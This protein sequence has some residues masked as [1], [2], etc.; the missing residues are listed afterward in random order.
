MNTLEQAQLTHELQDTSFYDQIAKDCTK[1]LIILLSERG[2]GKS[3]SL[4]TIVDHC[5]RIHPNLSFKIFDVSQAWYHNAPVQHRQFVNGV[6][7]VA[8]LDDCVYEIGALNEAQRRE[9]V[10][11]VVKQDWDYRYNLKLLNPYA[12][13]S[14]PWVIYVFEEANVYFGSYSFRKND[15]FSQVLQDF[16]SVGRNYRLGGFLVATAEQGE[17][18]PSLR[19]RTK[20]LYGKIISK[21]DLSLA[22]QYD[23]E[24]PDKLKAM[25]RFHFL[26]YS[27]KTYGP[28]KIPDIVKTVP[29][30]YIPPV[31][32]GSVGPSADWWFKFLV[33]VMGFSILLC[34]AFRYFG[35]M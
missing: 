10:G 14:L 25:K 32:E 2:H 11:G 19:R 15:A 33:K 16:V 29:V 4:K 28:V 3:T 31:Y 12:L 17:I 26:Y 5:K 1:D 21:G 24:L 7:V 27:G 34:L 18:S 23:K 13:E 30:N 35:F 9:F 8:N 20:K 6:N 22:K